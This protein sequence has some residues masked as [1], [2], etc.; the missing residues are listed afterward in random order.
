MKKILLLCLF[1]FSLQAAV[2]AV[3]LSGDE[4]DAN[5]DADRDS[6][7]VDRVVHPAAD[8]SVFYDPQESV[9]EFQSGVYAG[10]LDLGAEFT[11]LNR[12][13]DFYATV[14]VSQMIRTDER[15]TDTRSGFSGGITFG[16]E[17]VLHTSSDP[18]QDD[19]RI[20]ARV[21]PG[22][23]VSGLSRIQ[24]GEIETHFGLHTS[25]LVGVTSRVSGF[26]RPYIEIGFRTHWFP[27]LDEFGLAAAPQVSIGFMF[28]GSREI[29]PVRF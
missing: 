19:T 11:L 18:Y 2:I 16:R 15:F 27:T 9:F 28:S 4:N 23:G 10:T 25:A 22:I 20:Y 5:S 6:V 1:T 26:G 3:T 12:Y 29:V 17:Y 13:Y 24:S 7:K 8:P 14:F 21:G